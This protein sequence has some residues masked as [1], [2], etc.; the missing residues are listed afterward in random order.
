ME[1]PSPVRD[2]AGHFGKR[3]P[4]N[5]HIFLR[6]LLSGIFA[7]IL[8]ACSNGAIS[9]QGDESFAFSAR[10]WHEAEQSFRGDDH[11]LGGD[12]AYSVDLKS[13]RVLWI[14][15]D[16]FIGKGESRQRKDASLV[17]N[18]VAVQRGYDPAEAPV[19]FYWGTKDGL[20]DAF[21][22]S[23]R[24]N[25]YW[26]GSGAMVM[27]RLLVFLM[28]I[29]PSSGGFGFAAKGWAAVMIENPGEEPGLWKKSRLRTPENSFGVVIGSAC[30]FVLDGYLYAFGAH[31]LDH[32]AYPVRWNLTDAA[33]GN[34][35]NP[36]W[37]TGEAGWVGQDKLT[38][39]PRALFPDAQMEYTVHYESA[40]GRFVEVQTD[41]FTGHCLVYRWSKNLTGPWSEKRK[42]Y[43][44]PATETKDLLVYAGKAHHSLKGAD[45][46]CTYAL[47]TLDMERLMGDDSVYYPVFIKAGMR[48]AGGVAD[49]R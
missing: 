32:G 10:R 44:P 16:S 34:L 49:G 24:S 20:P 26:P 1:A 17:R 43:C 35:M 6:I 14:F 7:Y 29:E 25:W 39:R 42:L 37:W 47:N 27:S 13:G 45:L 3:L 40:L 15:G 30:C 21:F 28:D 12:G 48:K 11:W 19:T 22:P 46:V 9:S 5:V 31:A 33:Q 18:T 36:Q 23:S 38:R 41:S 4:L 8:F 2:R